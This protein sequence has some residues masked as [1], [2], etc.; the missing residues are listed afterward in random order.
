MNLIKMRI[1]VNT[2]TEELEELRHAVAIIEDAIK[3]RENPDLYEEDYEQE[4]EEKPKQEIS[5]TQQ[6][7]QQVQ[8]VQKLQQQLH[9]DLTMEKP[10]VEEPKPHVELNLTKPP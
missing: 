6:I 4:A 9:E 1:S 8:E 7:K 3:R 5:A 10:S 2:E